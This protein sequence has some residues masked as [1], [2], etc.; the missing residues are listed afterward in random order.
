MPKTVLVK[1]DLPDH[2]FSKIQKASVAQKTTIDKCIQNFLIYGSLQVQNK[3]EDFQ[4]QLES[5]ITS[6]ADMEGV[7]VPAL[8]HRILQE[9]YV[10]EKSEDVYQG[11]LDFQAKI[12]KIS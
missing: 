3:E 7:S 6:W 1:I 10:M 5:K 2:I 12:N 9:D 4:A 8:I 11:I